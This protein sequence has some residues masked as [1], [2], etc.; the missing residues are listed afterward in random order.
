MAM[1]W[2]GSLRTR[3]RTVS[4]ALGLPLM[5]TASWVRNLR[6]S[7]ADAG[8]D[9]GWSVLERRGKVQV[10]HS[11]LG[12]DGNRQ[13]ATAMLPIPWE[14][15]CTSAVIEAITAL[16]KALKSGQSLSDAAGLLNRST[17]H[18]RVG[19]NWQEAAARFRDHK[20]SSGKVTSERRFDQNDGKNLKKLLGFI[21]D[22]KPQS[23]TEIAKLATLGADGTALNPGTGRSTQ[24]N[25][26]FQFLDYCISELGF[27]ERWAPPRNR[28]AF[29]GTVTAKLPSKHH[30]AGKA[31]PIPEAAIPTLLEGIPDPRWRL[32][33]GL[34]ICFGLRGVELKY[35]EQRDGQLWTTYCKRTSKGET[36][37]RP[38]VGLDPELMP[39]LSAQ[40]QVEL[41]SGITALPP[42]GNTDDQASAAVNTYLRRRKVWQ[43]LKA[44]ADANGEKLSTYSF[45]HR[46]AAAADGRGFSDRDASALMGNS[47][48]T[49][50]AHYGE[51]TR[52]EELLARA[53]ELA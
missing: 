11:W 36:K 34:I 3:W 41:I 12:A 42:L 4:K 2:H 47:R 38:L 53:A 24:V 30:N 14:K 48:Q 26:C 18:Q 46:Y 45:R 16:D 5:V 23:G 1:L 32:A 50:V 49:F 43:D 35:L 27:D 10:Q 33:V 20:L 15:G 17:A 6:G 39:G 25:T 31:A 29:K 7:V 44:Q 52:V 13:K 21:A 19:L 22:R 37:P 28:A 8:F 51:F 9:A 40:L